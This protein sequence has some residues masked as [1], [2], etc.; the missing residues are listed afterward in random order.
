MV[1]R[2]GRIQAGLAGHD[3]DLPCECGFAERV[4]EKVN[5]GNN[6]PYL[7]IF[8]LG[9]CLLD[10]LS[11]NG[12]RW[13]ADLA[14][15]AWHWLPVQMRADSTHVPLTGARRLSMRI[16]GDICLGPAGLGR[17]LSPGDLPYGGDGIGGQRIRDSRLPR[18]LSSSR[19]IFAQEAGGFDQI[20]P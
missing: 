11:T 20:S 19:V 2:P 4:T 10:L 15:E 17:T 12:P 16:V 18:P 5:L 8:W 14:R 9:T 6:V 13:R 1:Q 7:P 3:F